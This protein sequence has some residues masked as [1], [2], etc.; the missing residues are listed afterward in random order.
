MLVA[1]TEHP[2]LAGLRS[3][4]LFSTSGY[5]PGE[6]HD[7]A[8]IMIILHDTTY[9]VPNDVKHMAE[10]TRLQVRFQWSA[11]VWIYYFRWQP[12]GKDGGNKE[13]RKTKSRIYC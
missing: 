11:W 9:M 1:Q 4:R 7:C 6:L 8:S 5:G 3:S 10:I 13:D 12:Q 2:L